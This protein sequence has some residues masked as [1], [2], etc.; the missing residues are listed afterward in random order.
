MTMINTT[1]N[2]RSN[3]SNKDRF[4]KVSSLIFVDLNICSTYFA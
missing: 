4:K 3:K 1:K 2:A